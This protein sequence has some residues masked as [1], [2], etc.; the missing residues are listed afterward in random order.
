[1]VEEHKV[2]HSDAEGRAEE[3]IFEMA[4]FLLTAARGC[5]GEPKIYGSFRL[6]DA[7]SRLT[8][9]YARSDSLK[10]DPFLIKAKREIDANKY[11]V[12]A[13]DEE[14]IQFMDRIILEFADELKRRYNR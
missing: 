7:V 9:I 11:R 8:D 2:N 12:M 10:P 13:S 6:V 5:V 1:L 3:H 14:F 4:L